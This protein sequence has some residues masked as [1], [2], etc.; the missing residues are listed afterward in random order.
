MSIYF[1]LKAR[2]FAV[3]TIR[4]NLL[5]LRLL[6]SS[7]I[8]H[9][10]SNVLTITKSRQF[11]H[12]AAGPV[13]GSSLNTNTRGHLL[14]ILSL[15]GFKN[16]HI[17][18]CHNIIFKHF[19][20]W[21]IPGQSYVMGRRKGKKP[22]VLQGPLQNP[23][24]HSFNSL[25]SRSTNFDGSKTNQSKCNSHPK[26]LKKFQHLSK[27]PTTINVV[28]I[29]TGGP[30]TS[31]SILVTTEYSRYMF[32]CGEGTQRLAAMSKVLRTTAF[33]KI[34]GLET[35]FITHKSW[36]NTGGL[37]GM[38]MTLEG[39]KNPDSKTYLS[40]DISV[41]A[42]SKNVPEVKIYGPPNVENI[43]MMAKKFSVSS[44]MNIAKGEGVYEDFAVKIEPVRFFKDESQRN[45]ETTSVENP[46]PAKKRQ[47][48]Q[49]D[50]L[51]HNSRDV[52]FAYIITAKAP[53]PKI[54]V[55]KCL[56]AGITIGPMVGMLQRGQSVVLENGRVVHPEEVTDISIADTRPFLVL[57]CPSLEFLPS[58]SKNKVLQEYITEN[59]E[60]SFSI[61]IH[62]TPASVFNSKDYQL[63]MKRLHDSTDHLVLNSDA[64]AA[65]LIR[66]RDHQA[67]LNLV[68]KDLFPLLPEIDSGMTI[69]AD[70]KV[71]KKDE[72]DLKT[73]K[74][75]SNF[76]EK[77]GKVMMAFSGLHYV[78]R[79]KRI[80]F[81]VEIDE[82]NTRNIQQ[83]YLDVPEIKRE[84]DALREKMSATPII[85]AEED[86]KETEEDC[87]TK[88]PKV[89]FMG[90]GSSE[91]NRIR[92]Q[93]C[94]VAQLSKHTVV[95][96]DCGEDSYGQI[97]RFF[98]SAK[99]NRILTKVKAVFISHMH[100]DHHLGLITL[101]KERQKAFEEKQK[102]FSP[103]LLIA[104]IQMRRWLK[105]YHTEFEPV[106]S[107]LR[108]VKL[109]TLLSEYDDGVS[110]QSGSFEDVSRELN[111]KEFNPVP[112][113]HCNNAFGVALTHANGF[114]L[115]Y[116]GDTRPC[117]ALIKAG[118][119]CDLLIHEATHDDSLLAHAKASKHSTFSEAMDVG[120]RMNARHII[121]T[122]FSQRYPHM[123]PF[124]DMTL[125][126]NVGVAFDNM[127][128]CPRTLGH[129]PKLI[130]ALTELFADEL[131]RLEIKNIKRIREQTEAETEDALKC[132]VRS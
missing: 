70:L 60:K 27:V 127:Q 126:K 124:F 21:I 130:P 32:N 3:L 58:L 93:S 104:P 14:Q 4:P 53:L 61:V 29:G 48:R 63:W 31:K 76:L 50:P 74:P 5:N 99:A 39:Q 9:S 109:Q 17:R 79:G 100:G 120:K 77:N 128:V 90:T 8:D 57:E 6:Q 108:F 115:V 47:R 10:N 83:R 112:V 131:Q 81:Q 110:L 101:L 2:L 44:N 65:D 46:E 49:S 52:A 106:T 96:L 88:Y 12:P 118:E 41:K 125:P 121:L 75:E 105:F 59:P 129:L 33:A 54:N 89:A 28:V 42:F 51:V 82:F 40:R 1:V 20:S 68:S 37:L 34:S 113:D 111:L 25:A 56:D 16:L 122:H 22:R 78:C 35:I 123:T 95:I 62:M 66:V 103:A 18:I 24:L 64:V 72:D 26:G 73:E 19:S 102:A 86:E 117:D 38:A 80:G 114:K 43:A 91:P 116:S 45:K 30:G 13:L 84:L 94:I 55:E 36:E 107:L 85:I 92:A 67:R 98:G 71:D 69:D 23:E 97:Y 119:K 11:H 15:N 132:C 7:P 87:T